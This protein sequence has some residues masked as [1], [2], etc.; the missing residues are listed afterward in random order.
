MSTTFDKSISFVF[1]VRFMKEKKF[2]KNDK[3]ARNS[4]SR[5]S[6]YVQKSMRY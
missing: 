1:I 6:K 5:Y 2:E 4:E 3:F